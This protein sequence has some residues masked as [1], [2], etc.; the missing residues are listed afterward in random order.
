MV[1]EFKRV[2]SNGFMQNDS[3]QVPNL[4]TCFNVKI[5]Q[6]FSHMVMSFLRNKL[7][8]FFIW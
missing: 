5:V 4:E 7:I 3:L 6:G 1:D 8:K 2:E